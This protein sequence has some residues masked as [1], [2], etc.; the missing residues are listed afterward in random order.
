M[1]LDACVYPGG[2]GGQCEELVEV[3][4]G[5]VRNGQLD[6]EAESVRESEDP[7]VDV[8]EAHLP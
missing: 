1:G 7:R 6:A 5:D 4:R 2:G 8:R 3:E